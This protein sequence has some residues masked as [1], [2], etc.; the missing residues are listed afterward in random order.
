MLTVDV[1]VLRD[2]DDARVRP[3]SPRLMYAQAL[4]ATRSDQK[5]ESPGATGTAVKRMG[6]S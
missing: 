1:L 2:P 5:I 4:Q 3:L 6:R